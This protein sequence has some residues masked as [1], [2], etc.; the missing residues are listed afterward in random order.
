MK[1]RRN[2]EFFRCSNYKDGRGKCSFHF[3]R[4]VVLE[5]I[6]KETIADLADFVRCYE[7]VFLFMQ[8]Q[9]C[10]DFQKKQQQ[11]LKASIES[12]RKRIADLNN[13]FSRIYEDNVIGKLSDERYSRMAVEYETEQNELL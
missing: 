6:V 3:I 5:T 2:Q 1:K 10:G 4:D 11:T 13:L 9:K 7:P 12:S 8:K